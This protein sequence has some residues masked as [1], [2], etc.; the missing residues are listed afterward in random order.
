MIPTTHTR[1]VV[2]VDTG[3]AFVNPAAAARE[4]NRRAKSTALAQITGGDVVT[5]IRFEREI[6]GRH[7]DWRWPVGHEREGELT[8]NNGRSVA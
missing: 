7:F 3:E 2:C 6:L 8:R 5:A 4:L 1:E